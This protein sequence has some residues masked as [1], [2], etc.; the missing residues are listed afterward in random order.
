MS[1]LE[2][3]LNIHI[4][5]YSICL[6]N[7]NAK[8][9]LLTVTVMNGPHAMYIILS[10]FHMSERQYLLPLQMQQ[11]STS[12]SLSLPSI[13][14]GMTTPK[15]NRLH[16]FHKHCLLDVTVTVKISG[17]TSIPW[18]VSLNWLENA[19][20]CPLFFGRQFLTRKVGHTN[21]AFGM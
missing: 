15:V 16:T 21:L 4:L 10:L 20:S 13:V 8:V 1:V 14:L 17:L 19:Y 9:L 5:Y 11:S 2:H 12:Q 7:N 18:A 3:K 6:T